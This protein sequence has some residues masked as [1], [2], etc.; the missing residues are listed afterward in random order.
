M[1]GKGIA[2]G[3]NKSLLQIIG[4]KFLNKKISL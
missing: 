3:K 1:F 4:R 2:D